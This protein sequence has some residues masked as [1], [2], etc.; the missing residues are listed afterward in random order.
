MLHQL[1]VHSVEH[2]L[3]SLRNL[4]A[5]PVEIKTII[6]PLPEG[7]EDE[8]VDVSSLPP[9]KQSVRFSVQPCHGFCPYCPSQQHQ[10]RTSLSKRSSASLRAT[11]MP[12]QH[13][14]I[15]DEESTKKTCCLF[16]TSLLL[17]NDGLV[18]TPS[19]AEFKTALVDIMDRFQ[20]C[21]L[22]VP[23]LIPDSLFHSFTRYVVD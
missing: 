8:D 2:L 11:P 1:T 6:E 9:V 7:G 22:A 23:N 4:V 21:T 10:S 19:E 5:K 17:E 20:E 13:E 15:D 14:E 12:T 18:Y 16:I 3:K